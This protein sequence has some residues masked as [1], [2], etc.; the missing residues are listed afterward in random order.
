MFTPDGREYFFNRITNES[1]WE[2]PL[3]YTPPP[4]PKKEVAVELYFTCIDNRR[5]YIPDSDWAIVLTNFNHEFFYRESDKTVSWDI[6]DDI[7][8]LIGELLAE[9]MDLENEAAEKEED[10]QESE[11]QHNAAIE[12]ST[13]IPSQIEEAIENANTENE[14][15]EVDLKRKHIENEIHQESIFE[16]SKRPKL[17][18]IQEPFPDVIEPVETPVLKSVQEL[19]SDF[20]VDIEY[21]NPKELLKE[22]S[23]SPFLTWDKQVTLLEADSRYQNIKNFKER[24]QVFDQFCA[25]RSQEIIQEKKKDSESQY[26]DLL[27]QNVQIRTRFEDFSRKFKRDAKF[28]K[29]KDPKKRESLFHE[30]VQK[31]KKAQLEQLQNDFIELLK[32]LDLSSQSVWSTTCV[33]I[34]KDPRFLAIKNPTEREKMFRKYTAGLK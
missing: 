22:K 23:I 18:Q 7:V 17:D 13:D 16:D 12:E 25:Q 11:I 26:L 8:D 34:D 30:H 14:T 24:K 28:V 19:S 33:K 3:D 15:K 27:E 4:P 29:F 2:R 9:A 21:F 32:T 20:M 10:M 1:V 6:P 31:L 5:K